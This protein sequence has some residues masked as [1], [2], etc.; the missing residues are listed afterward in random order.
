MTS[1]LYDLPV[2][3]VNQKTKIVELTNEYLVRDD[4]GATV[5][6][7]CEVGQSNLKKFVR[8]MSSYDQFF[9]HKLE[10]RDAD[11][12]PL[13]VLTRPRKFVKSRLLV[14]K[15]DGT[16]VGEIVQDNVFGKIHFSLSADGQTLGAISAENWR[17]WNFAITDASGTEVARITKTWEGLAKTLFTTADN[18]ALQRHAP[19]S[20]TL[21]D[22]VLAAALC[23]DTAL[24]QD[25]RGLN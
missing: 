6:S 10:V 2:L 14:E 17:A 1:A 13:L 15:P 9:T 7:V 5:G 22:L 25:D 19:I 4:Q 8:A 3:V 18:Y 12:T 21:G 11:G 24:K 20:G 23:I 16:A